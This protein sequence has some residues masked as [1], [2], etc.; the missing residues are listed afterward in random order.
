MSYMRLVDFSYTIA[1]KHRTY[2]SSH[3]MLPMCAHTNTQD[4][5]DLRGITCKA[6]DS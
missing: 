1:L 3:Y 5:F 4:F 6:T 2:V